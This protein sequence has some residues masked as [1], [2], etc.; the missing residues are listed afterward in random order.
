M[1][2]TVV[3]THGKIGQEMIRVTQS[4][5]REELNMECI[6][7]E[8]HEP[9]QKI[10]K[11]IE[12]AIQDEEVL[13][14]TDMFGGTPSNLCLPFLCKG[15]VEVITGVNLPMLIKLAHYREN[16]SLKRL[17][18]FIKKYGQKNITLATQVLEKG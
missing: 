7:I 4:I 16:K 9:L 8:H 11:K 13:L 14:L 10:R 6:C 12:A 15:K 2:K 18:T 5:V 1:I 3:V 17:A